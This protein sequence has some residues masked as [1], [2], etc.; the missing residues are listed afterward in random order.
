MEPQFWIKAWNEGRTAFHQGEVHE[1]LLKYFPEL[2]PRQGGARAR[3]P[4][5]EDERPSLA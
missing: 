1:K 3:A 2:H 4:L 5:R